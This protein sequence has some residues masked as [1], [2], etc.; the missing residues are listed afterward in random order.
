MR[1]MVALGLVVV[2]TTPVFG[3][4][5]EYEVTE[6]TSPL[7]EFLG[8]SEYSVREHGQEVF[9][10]KEDTSPLDEVLKRKRFRLIDCSQSFE[11]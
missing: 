7:G 11:C 2:M 4:D 9:R 3:Y 6:D 5:G 1:W 8:R 10:M